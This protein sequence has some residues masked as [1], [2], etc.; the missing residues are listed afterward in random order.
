MP[1]RIHETRGGCHVA[2]VRGVSDP[3]EI[4]L[5]KR[6]KMFLQV[7]TPTAFPVFDEGQ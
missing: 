3:G 5:V 2:P 7:G 4:F 1:G 6:E